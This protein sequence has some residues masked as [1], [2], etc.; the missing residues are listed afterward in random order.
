MSNNKDLSGFQQPTDEEEPIDPTENFD[1]TRKTRRAELEVVAA[2]LQ[3]ASKGER[4]KPKSFL[5]AIKSIFTYLYNTENLTIQMLKDMY[6]IVQ[7]VAKAE[8]NIFVLMLKMKTLIKLLE[9]KELITEEELKKVHDDEI[10][11]KEMQGVPAQV[12]NAVE[13]IDQ[14]T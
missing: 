5:D 9:N 1:T 8:M 3:R 10:I 12:Q 2:I 6:G 13:K 14:T 11:P 7:A 4:L